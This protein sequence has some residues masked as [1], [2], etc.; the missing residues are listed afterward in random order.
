VTDEA[1]EEIERVPLNLRVSE[2]VKDAYEDAIYHERGC[3]TPYAAV[4]LEDELRLLLDQ[5]PVAELWTTTGDLLDTLG[6]ERDEKKIETVSVDRSETT[7]VGYQ[8]AADVRAGV[9]ELADRDSFRSA[10]EIVE[11]V[12]RLYATSG[13]STERIQK[14]VDQLEDA[15]SSLDTDENLGVKQRRTQAIADALDGGSFTLRDFD[16]AVDEHAP[17]ISSGEYAR[18]EYLERVLDELE[19]TWTESSHSRF[20]PEEEVDPPDLRNPRYM[21]PDLMSDHDKKLAIACKAYEKSRD[22]QARAALFDATEAAEL[23]GTTPQKARTY[24]RGLDVRTG[25]SYRDDEDALSADADQIRNR[26]GNA[27]IC[28]I[29]HGESE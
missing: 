26:E 17:R 12:M 3:V 20:K 16:E 19:Y 18:D 29:F 22:G 4:T 2:S 8:I 7:V 14:R 13:S 9:M 10:G 24:L 27:D 15:V 21:P 23:L 6:I 5:G 11:R 1:R 28:R 25:F